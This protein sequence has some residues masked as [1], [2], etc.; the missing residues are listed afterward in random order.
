[1]PRSPL[2]ALPA[3]AAGLQHQQ[4]RPVS[5]LSAPC[6]YLRCLPRRRCRWCRCRCRLAFR[7]C[8]AA[9]RGRRSRPP[10]LNRSP[11]LLR[12]SALFLL[13][14]FPFCVASSVSR[15]WN[16]ACGFVSS[17]Y[18]I[19]RACVCFRRFLTPVYRWT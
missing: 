4:Q 5:P 3:S 15:M 18:P 1:V 16:V 13:P 10:E 19:E 8:T 7:S 14:L 9:G 11:P 12:L 17:T 6:G 2:L